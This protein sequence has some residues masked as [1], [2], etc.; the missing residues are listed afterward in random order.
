M[1]H[2]VVVSLETH[3]RR[4]GEIDILPWQEF[5]ARLWEGVYS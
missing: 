1:K 2:S 5:L 3:P 4:V